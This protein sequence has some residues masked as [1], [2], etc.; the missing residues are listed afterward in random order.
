MVGESGV[1]K[2]NILT[3]FLKDKFFINQPNTIGVEFSTKIVELEG[4][5]VKFMLWDTAGQ[6][7][8]RAVVSAYYRY[9]AF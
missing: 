1:G 4:E 3:R 9:S 7:K 5:K 2:T 8:Y 6:E